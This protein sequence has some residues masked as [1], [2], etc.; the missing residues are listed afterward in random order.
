ME[1][2]TDGNCG[3]YS[4]IESSQPG[5]LEHCAGQSGSPTSPTTHNYEAQQTLRDIAVDWLLADDP[6]R[7]KL[8]VQEELVAAD[9]STAAIHRFR[10][11]K[12][13]PGQP[14]GVYAPSALLRAVAAVLQCDVASVNSRTCEDKV[15]LYSHDGSNCTV[16]W[17]D[18][19]APRVCA[20]RDGHA[21]GGWRLCVIIWNGRT[22]A[23]SH[24]DATW[25]LG[26]M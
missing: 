1:R 3:L 13:A 24:F 4:S 7:R 26:R 18:E 21:A 15:A 8:I 23:S 19:V 12:N 16:S 14:M 25:P 6:G 2:Q 20:Q 17:T 10:R 11:G 22:D 9:G 5:T